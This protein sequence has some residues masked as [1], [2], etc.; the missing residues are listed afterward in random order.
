MK[1]CADL[2]A[3]SVSLFTKAISKT[4]NIKKFSI[5]GPTFL[6]CGFFYCIFAL[7]ISQNDQKMT[8]FRDSTNL[9]HKTFPIAY[10]ENAPSKQSTLY[11]CEPSFLEKN[12]RENQINL[13]NPLCKN[14]NLKINNEKSKEKTDELLEKELSKILKDTPMEK[15]L[16]SLLLQK[17][18]VTAFLVGIAFKES[19][20]GVYSPKKNG[21]E[22]FNYW[23]FKG[24]QTP[25]RSGYSC[26]ATPEE[27]VEIVGKRI[28]KLVI[29]NKRSTPSQMTVWKCG[30][31]CA[32][33]SPQGVR[34]WISD[35]A[36]FYN[37]I[38]SV[39]S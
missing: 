27:A 32:S 15:M 5:I 6:V 24:K 19:K 22:C 26:F 1:R 10:A 39:K 14:E 3:K 29:D 20:F 33:H 34:K 28:E 4:T 25:T 8:L 18:P 9:L 30:S 11:I 35:V 17:K 31:S 13:V 7:N 16:D 23:G 37:Q 2:T 38:M 12:S 36:I 21:T